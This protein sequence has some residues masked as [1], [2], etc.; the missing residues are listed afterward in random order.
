LWGLCGETSE[1]VLI[2]CHILAKAKSC[3][4]GC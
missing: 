2:G 1:Y 4:I 3:L